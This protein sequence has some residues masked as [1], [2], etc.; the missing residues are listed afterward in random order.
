M[1]I[2]NAT[3]PKP[4]HKG[5]GGIGYKTWRDTAIA[6]L[7]LLPFLVLYFTFTLFPIVQ[8]FWISLHNWEI[9]GTNIHFIGPQNYQ[10]LSTDPMFWKAFYNTVWFVLLTIPIIALALVFAL[11]LDRPAPGIGFFRT[12][13]Y[14]PNVLS[15]AVIGVIW[16]RIFASSDAGLINAILV[17]FGFSVVPWLNSK[18]LAMPSV[19]MATVWWTVGFN[20]LIFL[21]GLQSINAELYDAAK[22]DGANMFRRFFAVTLPGLQRTMAF[23]T[24]LQV[25]ASFQI[26]GQVDIMTKGG[27]A[28]ETRTMVYYIWE[29][30]FEFWQLGYG[31][32]MSFIL[33]IVLLVLS[34]VQL[35]AFREREA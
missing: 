33:F 29:R 20:T 26:F 2:S 27:P 16:G 10:R 23:V 14:V 1:A 31:A 25:I 30:A 15:V 24:V 11:I 18:E 35:F 19:A 6:Y 32:A 9:V 5:W 34:I 22:V 8:S 12:L 4:A 13:Y 28:G 7:F 17:K 21:A 3:P